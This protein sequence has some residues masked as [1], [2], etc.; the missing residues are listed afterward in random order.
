MNEFLRSL[1]L[2]DA[3]IAELL[4]LR[5]EGRVTQPFLARLAAHFQKAESEGVLNPARH[6][7]EILGVQRQTVLTYMRMAQRNGL[8]RKDT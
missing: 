7:A 6:F 1:R 2:T 5:G 3:E 4:R 8:T